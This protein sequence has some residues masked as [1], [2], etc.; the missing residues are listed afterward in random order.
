MLVLSEFQNKYNIS[1]RELR[2]YNILI[3]LGNSITCKSY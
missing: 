2:T 3:S 1:I